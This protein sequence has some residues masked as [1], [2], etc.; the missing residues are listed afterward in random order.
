MPP[1]SPAAAVSPWLCTRPSVFRAPLFH[2]EERRV[3]VQPLQVPEFGWAGRAQR[4]LQSGCRG[5]AEGSRGPSKVPMLVLG[6]PQETIEGAPLSFRSCF[7][8]FPPDWCRILRRRCPRTGW[9]LLCTW[10]TRRVACT[11]GSQSLKYE[12]RSSFAP[13]PQPRPGHRRLCGWPTG[14]GECW[15]WRGRCCTHDSF[16]SADSAGSSC[17]AGT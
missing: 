5:A 4:A 15:R 12:P 17:F 10:R 11:V 13:P 3:G 6:I 1:W 16:D 14:L 2:R 8:F 9:A 7:R